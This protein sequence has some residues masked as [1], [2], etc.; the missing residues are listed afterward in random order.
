MFSFMLL[1][2]FMWWHSALISL[3]N[4]TQARIFHQLVYIMTV[5]SVI[6]D[7]QI[8]LAHTMTRGNFYRKASRDNDIL[9]SLRRETRIKHCVTWCLSFILLQPCAIYIHIFTTVKSLLSKKIVKKIL[10]YLAYI[11]SSH[12]MLPFF[13]ILVASLVISLE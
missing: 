9:H 1:V 3:S 11:F 7:S 4:L 10:K 2:L 13:I 6:H 8:M 5:A 12:F